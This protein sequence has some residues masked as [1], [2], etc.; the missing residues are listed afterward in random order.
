VTG[1]VDRQIQQQIQ[2]DAGRQDVVRAT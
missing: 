1:I 2:R